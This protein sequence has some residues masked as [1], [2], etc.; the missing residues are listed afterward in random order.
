MARGTTV[1]WTIQAR[2]YILIDVKFPPCPPCGPFIYVENKLLSYPARGSVA[3][4]FCQQPNLKTSTQKKQSVTT[5]P[6]EK[7]KG[8]IYPNPVQ[9]NLNVK[10][11]S[12]SKNNVIKVFDVNGRIVITQQATQGTM[13]LNVSSLSNGIYF[14]RIENST[15]KPLHTARFIKE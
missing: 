2:R 5:A 1:N 11:T 13:Q 4:P 7:I 14:L 12:T 9:S 8:E 15:G 10:Y 6:K 3:I